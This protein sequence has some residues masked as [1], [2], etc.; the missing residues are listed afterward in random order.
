MRIACVLL[1]HLPLKLELQRDQNLANRQVVIFERHGSQRTVLDT[2]PVIQQVRRGMPLQE[3]QT[4][5]KDAALIEADMPRYQQAFNSVLLRLGEWSPDIE[6]GE[7]GC[8][9]VGLDGLEETYGSE[10]RLIDAL[11]Q[12]VPRYLEPRLG[13]SHGKFPAYLA[14]L[15]A[16]P[17]RAYKPPLGV[18][19][20]MAPFP[21]EVLPMPWEVKARLRSFGLDTLGKIT[22]LSLGPLQ[23]QFGPAGTRM[24]HLA[25]GRDDT[26]LIPRR[27]EENLS[28]TIA[29]P[30]PTANIEPLL[31]ALDHLLARLFSQPEMRG[32]YARVA[33]LE[34]QVVRKPAWQKRIVFKVPVGERNRAYFVLKCAVADIVLP[35]PLEDIRLTL[36]ELTGESGRQ[37]SLFRDVR[38]RDQLRQTVAQ[39][40]VAQGKNPIY[41]VRETEPWSR[42]PE[43]QRVLVT[44]EP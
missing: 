37:E 6:S 32:R 30:V 2:S 17:G 7:L 43:R 38:R 3:A 42:I 19:Q 31:M 22:E 13:I 4:R 44:Y 9:Y 28:S 25:Q 16:E 29:F 24:W 35:G 27:P 21:V 34:G 15:R 12:A 23:A 20:F 8:A 18:K 41:Q 1:N 14:A 39:L 36:R 5:C 40:K 33:L 10:E 11:L 26:P